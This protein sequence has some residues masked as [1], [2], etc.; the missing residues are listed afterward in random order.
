MVEDSAGASFML[1]RFEELWT[2]RC[3]VM[4]KELAA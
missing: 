4:L 1:L 2:S 3:L